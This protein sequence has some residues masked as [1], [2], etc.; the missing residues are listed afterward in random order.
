MP[1]IALRFQ[2]LDIEDEF[3][4][5][6]EAVPR[7]GPRRSARVSADDQSRSFRSVAANVCSR[8]KLP[9]ERSEAD[10]Q[11]GAPYRPSSANIHDP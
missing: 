9:M 3:S 2:L 1:S 8:E 10:R 11:E 4:R 6:T 7:E 5:V